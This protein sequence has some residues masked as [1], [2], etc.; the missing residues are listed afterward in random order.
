MRLSPLLIVGVAL[1]L[2]SHTSSA[3][4]T[5]RRAHVDS[6]GQLRI[7]LSNNRVIRPSKD[8]G[9]VGFEQVT[10]SADRRTVGWVALYPNCCT[11]YS[12]PLRLVL[13]RA[14]GGRT[15]ISNELP[16][17]QWAFAADGRTVAIRQAPVH[18]AAETSYE[19]RDIR[20]GRLL[21]T[22]QSDSAT[23]PSALP[24]WARQA[25]PKRGPLPPPSHER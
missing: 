1:A 24:V 3:Q 14:D 9:Q 16:I 22:A 7:M 13:L 12:I 15:V 4:R 8:S 18:G 17:W 19:R 5:Y 23:P 21:A 25:M 10:M 11:S 20:T 2:G 6:M